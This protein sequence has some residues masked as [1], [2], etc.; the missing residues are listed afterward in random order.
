MNWGAEHVAARLQGILER[1]RAAQDR[2]GR[3]GEVQLVAVTKY[4]QP[5]QMLQLRDAGLRIFAE[6]RVQAALPKLVFFESRP[7]EQRPDAWHFIGHIQ[8]N[9]VP[10]LAG[11]FDLLHGVDGEALA[12]RLDRVC[13][14]RGLRQRILLQ[15]NISREERKHG[16]SAAE[17]EQQLGSLLELP[18]LA[19]AGLMGM[20][21]EGFPE[22]ARRAFRS[23]A[24]LRERLAQQYPSA[25]LAHLS[26]GMS[27]D[28]EIAVE[29][30]ATML[31]IGRLLYD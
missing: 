26:M 1:V 25:E 4:L 12:R 3:G 29:E 15:V 20:A 9:K 11:R 5:E 8:R 27:S 31:R 30:G 23:L 10:A 17:L 24:K 28:F 14:E 16:F 18:S 21:A 22:E 2:T 13:G 19:I 7:L 6:N